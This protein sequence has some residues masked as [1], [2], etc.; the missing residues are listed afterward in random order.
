MAAVFFDTLSLFKSCK[1]RFGGKLDYRALLAH[2]ADR[3][4]I[5]RCAAY[6][7]ANGQ[8][9][10]FVTAL[11]AA[12]VNEIVLC[13]EY[14]IGSLLAVDLLTDQ[15]L[16]LVVVTADPQFTRLFKAVVEDQDMGADIDLFVYTPDPLIVPK[17]LACIRLTEEF[18]I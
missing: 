6:V 4:K 1:R 9:A 17:G 3:F 8:E 11:Q 16:A 14:E 12:G 15:R 5:E 13:N 18:L 7:L 10:P 2:I